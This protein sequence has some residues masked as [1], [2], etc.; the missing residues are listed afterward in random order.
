MKALALGHV[1]WGL[2]LLGVAAWWAVAAFRILPY[3]STG[4][5]M[6]NLPI[7]LVLVVTQSG[8][9]AALG[10]WMLTLGRRIRAEDPNLRSL[11]LRTHGPLLVP[12]ALALVLAV[13]GLRAAERSA[14]RGGGLLAPVAVVPL[15]AGSCLAI[16]ALSSIAWALT[17]LAP[18]DPHSHR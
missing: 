18:P 15:V 7:S 13:Y 2:A 17:R 3:M 12:A 5:V 9:L 14:E 16:L 10:L 6:T 8:P 4:T 1:L 11:L